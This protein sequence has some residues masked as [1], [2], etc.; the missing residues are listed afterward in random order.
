MLNSSFQVLHPEY[1]QLA[2]LGRLGLGVTLFPIG[3]GSTRQAI[4]QAR[5]RPKVQGI[6][7]W[8]GVGTASLLMILKG[9]IHL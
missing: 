4:Q 8:I 1:L 9:W 6:L 3:T 2:R 7:L 5:A